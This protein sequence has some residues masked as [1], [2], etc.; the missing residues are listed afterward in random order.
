[1]GLITLPNFY[2]PFPPEMH[3]LVAEV[4]KHT[5][6]WA[7]R[8][9]LLQREAAL[10]RFR[11]SR[12]AWLA[13][14]VHARASFEELALTNDFFTWL[15]L[16]DDQFDDSSYGRQPVRMKVV[17]DRLLTVLG[18]E[19]GEAVQPLK[20]PIAEALRE[21]WERA[22]ALTTARWQ[23]RFAGHLRDYLDA[24]I[25]ET[26][27]RERAETPELGLYIRKRQD[28]G[29]MRLALDYIDL[30]EH[31]DLPPEIYESTLV[32]AL[33]LLTNNVVCWQ[34]DIV[35]VEKE[36]AHGDYS[37]LVLVLAK[38][39]NLSLQEGVERANAMTTSEIKLL[40]NLALLAPDAFPR[41]RA[42]LEK[43]L[44]CMRAWVRGNLDWSLES[45]RFSEIEASVEGHEPG[46]LESILSDE[47]I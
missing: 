40:E 1:M 12:F 17:V 28:A 35:S 9:H 11:A 36:L 24:Y 21:L 4:H 39:Y 3:P 34:N 31:V 8:H 32:Q 19:R 7:T 15:F 33:L 42:E 44:T 5:L 43:Y 41:H 10:R 20:G 22:G 45:S 16:L 27:L 26:G 23:R 25:W 13:A 14:R 29:A 18:I 47:A 46:Y 37:N 30:A 38:A 6:A 2:C